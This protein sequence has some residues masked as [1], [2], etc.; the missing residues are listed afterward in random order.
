M[1]YVAKIFTIDRKGINVTRGL[2]VLGI[3][4]ALFVVLT[5]IDQQKY[6]LT[7]AFAVLF[8]GL[9]DPGGPY[10]IRARDMAGVGLGGTVL[11]ALGFGIGGGPWGWVVLASFAI[12]LLGGLALK[13]GTHRFVDFY[14][15]NVW[16]LIALSVPATQH[17][18]P[19]RSDAWGQAV[20]WLV[21][22][23]LWIA[24]TLVTWLA[25]GRA[26]QAS[27]VPEIPGDSTAI[28]LTRPMIL[29]AVIRA[30]AV[31]IAAAIA[32]GLQ[33]GAGP[34]VAEPAAGR[35]TPARGGGRRGR[36]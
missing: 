8:V 1:S 10:A 12:T 30:V 4:L 6:Y 23:A 7:V 29:F 26:S 20:A 25:R 27:H 28:T 15:L 2:E 24:L 5:A 14:L 21:G 32:F 22:S 3:L 19:G 35:P 31:G 36:A 13:L 17:L 9:S 11:T 16:F 18:T 33:C 34:E